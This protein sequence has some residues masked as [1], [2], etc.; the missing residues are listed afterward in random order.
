MGELEIN[1]NRFNLILFITHWFV[2]N[3]YITSIIT[4][5]SG[6]FTALGVHY[7]CEFGLVSVTSSGVVSLRPEC[8]SLSVI[9]ISNSNFSL[10]SDYK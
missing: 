3:N 8:W 9:K 6:W 5:E 4:E 10:I 7:F 2:Y 1:L